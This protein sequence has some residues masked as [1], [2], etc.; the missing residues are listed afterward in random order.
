MG[1]FVYVQTKVFVCLVKTCLY[2]EGIKRRL[3][4]LLFNGNVF[5]PISLLCA[6]SVKEVYEMSI[7]L[8]FTAMNNRGK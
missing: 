2:V 7:D 8:S 3:K 4:L 5:P 1:I 6:A